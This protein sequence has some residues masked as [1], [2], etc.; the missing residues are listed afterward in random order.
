MLIQY[1]ERGEIVLIQS[2]PDEDSVRENIIAD[3][4][5]GDW[6][7]LKETKLPPE[8]LFTPKGAPILDD[9]GEQIIDSPGVLTP[10]V[11]HHL[12]YVKDG[13]VL[14][15]PVIPSCDDVTIK[16]DGK[17]K[18]NLSGLPKPIVVK[19]DETEYEITD[20]KI[21][22]ATTDPGTYRFVIDQ[23]PYVPWTM[24]VTA[25]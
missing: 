15:R 19:V 8:P 11:T 20:G 2:T 14:L 12:H 16:A 18:L 9:A 22:F 21:V 7:V 24:K 3:K 25:L 10:D 13:E 6:L 5:Y 4:T 17:D 23:W 1:T